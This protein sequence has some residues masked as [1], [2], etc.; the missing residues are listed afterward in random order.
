[1]ERRRTDGVAVAL[2]TGL[3]IVERARIVRSLCA[4][5]CLSDRM[6]FVASFRTPETMFAPGRHDYTLDNYRALLAS[7]SRDPIANSLFLCVASVLVSTGVS[8]IAAYVFSRMRFRMKRASSDRSCSGRRFP[9][10]SW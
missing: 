8:V 6:D 1:M 2:A 3:M 5:S 4:L 9:G 7:S 10:L